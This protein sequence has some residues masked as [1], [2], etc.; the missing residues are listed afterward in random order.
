MRAGQQAERD[1]RAG[2]DPGDELVV[3][4]ELIGALGQ[5]QL[6]GMVAEARLVE[7]QRGQRRR[8]VGIEVEPAV[9]RDDGGIVRQ[10]DRQPAPRPGEI[11][12]ARYGRFQQLD[13][14]RLV[15]PRQV[16]GIARAR[17]EVEVVGDRIDRSRRPAG[18]EVTVE[19]GGDRA[20]DLVLQREDVGQ[21]AVVAFGPQHLQAGGV[22]QL[23]VDADIGAGAAD[24][25]VE[26][27][28]RAERVGDLLRRLVG[29]AEL[30]A[31]GLAQHLQ[32]LGAGDGVQD[33]LAD[34][35]GEI[36]EVGIVR[37]VVEGEHGQQRRARRRRGGGVPRRGAEPPARGGPS[38][39]PA[40]P[41]SR[42][43][44]PTRAR[45]GRRPTRSGRRTG[46]G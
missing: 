46:P 25:T 32:P 15:R 6:L 38:R 39:R 27:V 11:G 12:R 22:D 2:I 42:R 40:R 21:P 19:R 37:Q 34:P 23:D 29:P 30:E 3:G 5:P 41:R 13:A 20:G 8:A 10:V 17:L 18:G 36:G 35:V 4:R 26:D 45:R 31:R 44:C 14:L 33:F 43:P 7:R 1:E 24:R 16:V 9:R 28:A